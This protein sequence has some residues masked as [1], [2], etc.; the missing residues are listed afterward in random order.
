M[1]CGVAYRYDGTSDDANVNAIGVYKIHGSAN[2]F[3]P[4][5]GGGGSNLAIARAQTKPLR[6]AEQEF[7]PALFNDNDLY[8]VHQRT[9]ALLEHKHRSTYCVLATYGPRKP[10]VYALPQ[11]E[12]VRTACVH[13]LTDRPP[14]RIIAVG[15]RPPV[16]MDDD[17][18]WAALCDLMSRL[19]SEK[20]YWSALEAER[21]A[22]S[23]FGFVG[24]NGWFDALVGTECA[25]SDSGG[26]RG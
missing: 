6:A 11:L 13:D 26:D 18:T 14:R 8:V 16:G 24:K 15:I 2:W 23:R 5:G 10:V 17:A 19:P 25:P 9:N 22:M 3:L 21:D 4:H 12:R 1:R 7:I 20:E